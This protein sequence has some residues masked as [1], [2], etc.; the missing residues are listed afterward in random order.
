MDGVKIFF[1]VVLL[2]GAGFLAYKMMS[3][4]NQPQVT[5]STTEPKKTLL[6]LDGH[7]EK[8]A[9]A[10]Y[11]TP[12]DMSAMKKEFTPILFKGN[13][14]LVKNGDVSKLT[15]SGSKVDCY[16]P[17]NGTD[18]IT[19]K[20]ND[21][22]LR[23]GDIKRMGYVLFAKNL[24]AVPSAKMVLYHDDLYWDITTALARNEIS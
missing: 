22:T 24:K 6:S 14:F 5:T 15:I 2:G 12:I 16:A 4:K 11:V 3:K 21:D 10:K 18:K 9:K 7:Q 20:I 23:N 17:K 1:G 8:V 13:T 19:I